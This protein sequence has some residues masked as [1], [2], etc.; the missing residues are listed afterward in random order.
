[1]TGVRDYELRLHFLN[2]DLERLREKREEADEDTAIASLD[3]AILRTEG[4][5]LEMED[6]LESYDEDP[7]YGTMIRNEEGIR[8]PKLPT[9]GN[10]QVLKERLENPEAEPNTGL[11]P[12]DIRRARE[13]RAK[14]DAQESIWVMDGR[15]PY[16]DEEERKQPKGDL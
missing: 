14:T 9:F 2:R 11:G 7:R 5:V 16:I 10:R 12:D 8:V 13:Y 4:R 15:S 3:E 1:M 6:W